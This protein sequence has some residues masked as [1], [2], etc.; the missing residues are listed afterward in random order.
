MNSYYK[1]LVLVFVAVLFSAIQAGAQ[2]NDLEIVHSE[3]KEIKDSNGTINV[4][5][6]WLNRPGEMALTVTYYGYLT[7]EG[8]VNFYININGVQ[9][10]FVTLKQEMKNRAQRIRLLSFHPTVKHK[11]ANKLAELPSDTVVDHMLFRNAPYYQQ[12]GNCDVE[13]IFFANGRWHGDS[14]KDN[15]NFRVSF[16]SPITDF[17]KSHF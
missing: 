9:R 11:K 7:Q 3:T 10:E 2:M 13:I 1:I 12:F 6:D 8:M 4:R 14:S 5:M 17:P 16:V 15:A